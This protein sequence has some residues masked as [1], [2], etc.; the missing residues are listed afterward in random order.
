[1]HK[2]QFISLL[3]KD[4]LRYVFTVVIISF[5]FFTSNESKAQRV[6][7]EPFNLYSEYVYN[8][9]EYHKSFPHVDFV[10]GNPNQ[11]AEGL[12]VVI[13]PFPERAWATP[14]HTS[15]VPSDNFR[16]WIEAGQQSLNGWK[17]FGLFTS[18]NQTLQYLD[19]HRKN[20]SAFALF[21]G[22]D[23][24]TERVPHG[25]LHYITPI[26]NFS[27][28]LHF[29]RSLTAKWPSE[30]AHPVAHPY[31]V[32]NWYF[33]YYPKE[34]FLN[35]KAEWADEAHLY[36][37]KNPQK[38]YYFDREMVWEDAGWF[39]NMSYG[40]KNYIKEKINENHYVI[41][42][43][44]KDEAHTKPLNI[45]YFKKNLW[46]GG[47]SSNPADL[48]TNRN[49]IAYPHKGFDD[50][51]LFVPFRAIDY[52]EREGIYATKDNHIC[53]GYYTL[54]LSN[55]GKTPATNHDYDYEGC[56]GL[57]IEVIEQQINPCDTCSHPIIVYH[58]EKRGSISNPIGGGC[59][60]EY[61]EY[62]SWTSCKICGCSSKPNSIYKSIDN[63]CIQHNLEE[64]SRSL[65]GTFRKVGDTDNNV[66]I[67][68]KVFDVKYKCQNY[69]CN[70]IDKKIEYNDTFN[71]Q[72]TRPSH[73]CPPHDWLY[74]PVVWGGDQI[75]REKVTLPPYN[76]ASIDLLLDSTN[77][78]MTRINEYTYISELPISR[79]QWVDINRGNNYLGVSKEDIGLLTNVTYQ[80]AFDFIKELNRKDFNFNFKITFSL[81]SVD[82]MR[83][84]LKKKQLNLE[85]YKVQQ[86]TSFY[87]DSIEVYDGKNRLVPAEKLATAPEGAKVRIMVGCMDLN[88][89]VKMVDIATCSDNIAFYLKAITSEEHVIKTFVQHGK[90]YGIYSKKCRSCGKVEPVVENIFFNMR[91][92]RPFISN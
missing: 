22:T 31:T 62:W 15:K 3:Q 45:E 70:Y 30:T 91:Y 57:D 34:Y 46:I 83:Q 16:V 52:W 58:N 10:Y 17:L 41:L 65:I 64:I 76:E 72:P 38:K 75:K 39:F 80:E 4:F 54:T 61:D 12:L 51:S 44:W 59:T 56:I 35:N 1:M 67:E 55:D 85:M 89:Q 13:E 86:I 29:A 84:L 68:T 20:K 90:F 21:I 36:M 66:I 92:H 40:N 19:I 50:W 48:Q 18:N 71:T 28:R 6:V 24:L 42:T 2:L 8:I 79:Q 7:E 26:F 74:G 5:S 32:R 43:F 63:R 14:L 33:R 87:V 77:I 78:E 53:Y 23:E 11:N 73:K 9:S 47:F 49:Y 27:F 69:C 60:R 88:G 25:D 81:P 82:E 37:D